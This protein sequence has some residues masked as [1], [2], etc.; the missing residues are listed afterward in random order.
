MNLKTTTT[1]RKGIGRGARTCAPLLILAIVLVFAI[2]LVLSG[3]RARKKPKRYEPVIFRH[4]VITQDL[5]G[6][7]GCECLNP[8]VAY[9]LDASTGK[10][11]TIAYC[12]GKVGQ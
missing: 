6:R 1:A 5:Y 2:A 4:C 11:R 3:C 7:N 12:D 10:T 9:E 8:L